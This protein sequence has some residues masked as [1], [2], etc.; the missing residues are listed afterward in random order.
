M[1]LEDLYKEVKTKY[2][3]LHSILFPDGKKPSELK[4]HILKQDEIDQNIPDLVSNYKQTLSPEIGLITIVI[5]EADFKHGFKLK[6]NPIT[7][8]NPIWERDLLHEIIHE[9]Q[10]KVL[11]I[12]S[13]EGINFMKNTN[14]NF[15]GYGHD[16]VF[17]TSLIECAKLLNIDPIV[18]NSNI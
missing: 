2:I 1:E 18:L 14:S 4:I 5:A 7:G 6:Y 9:Y 16:A 15:C 11:S 10:Y 3:E 13:K 17:Y 8:D 12:Y